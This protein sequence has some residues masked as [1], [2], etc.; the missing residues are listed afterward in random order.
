MVEWLIISDMCKT[1]FR[2]HE[3]VKKLLL[4]ALITSDMNADKMC[5]AVCTDGART[6]AGQKVD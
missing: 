5:Y 6:M 3:Y 4:T 2:N 1:M